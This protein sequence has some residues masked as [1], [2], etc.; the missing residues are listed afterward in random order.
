MKKTYFNKVPLKKHIMGRETR[1][2]K[3]GEFQNSILHK[4]DCKR[5]SLRSHLI[6]PGSEAQGN[7]HGI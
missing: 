7:K 3:D 2:N 1:L 5:K 4:G 6:V